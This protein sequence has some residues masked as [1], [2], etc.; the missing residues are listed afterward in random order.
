MNNSNSNYKYSKS[1]FASMLKWRANNREKYLAYQRDYQKKHYKQCK[2]SEA[3][4]TMQ[5]LSNE[6]LTKL[7]ALLSSFNVGN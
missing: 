6:Q 3:Q 7:V 1:R 5:L 4:A 2:L